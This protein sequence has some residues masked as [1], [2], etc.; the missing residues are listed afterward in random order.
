MNNFY[1]LLPI[2]V[3]TKFRERLKIACFRN[4]QSYIE[5]LKVTNYDVKATEIYLQ[6]L[7]PIIRKTIKRAI[8]NIPLT[9]DTSTSQRV[10]YS[11][12]LNLT[13]TYR[14]ILGL[15]QRSDF[16]WP[17]PKAPGW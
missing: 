14:P 10:R 2:F 1:I 13:K 8:Y 11:V 9:A 3:S 12:T 17:R 4:R 5:N 15:L 6:F 16:V 7:T